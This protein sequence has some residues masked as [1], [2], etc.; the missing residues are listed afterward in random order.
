MNKKLITIFSVIIFSLIFSTFALAED[1]SL[2]DVSLLPDSSFYFLK[3]WKESIQLFFT[4]NAEQKAKQY[5]H[6]ADIRLAEY[7]KMI[8]KGK[9]EIAEKTLGKYQNQLNRALLKAE[10][11]KNKGRDMENLKAQIEQITQK[12]LEI[13]GQNLQEV[14]EQAKKGIE[15][16]I[17]NSQKQ[18]DNIF[19][20]EKTCADKCGDGICQEI[21]CMA[22]GC[23]CAETIQSCSKDCGEE[24]NTSDWQTYRNEKQ[25]F[26]IKLPIISNTKWNENIKIDNTDKGI[27]FFDAIFTADLSKKNSIALTTR[28]NLFSETTPLIKFLPYCQKEKEIN[29]W[30]NKI[31]ITNYTTIKDSDLSIKGTTEEKCKMSGEHTTETRFCLNREMKVSPATL[32]KNEEYNYSCEDQ[33]SSLFLFNLD[34]FDS[35]L[36]EWKGDAGE[37]KCNQLF[38]QILPTFKFISQ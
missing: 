11:L 37:E 31:L 16:A 8:E 22:V 5:L 29:L 4:F 36:P 3:S 23:P 9:T 35:Q 21:V 12:H 6:L 33:K 24:I 17:E 10:E 27:Q 1:F 20:K 18:I 30:G 7:Q 25:G 15:N 38:D 14:P 13:L 34:C 26:E 32:N 19:P 2:P 28:R